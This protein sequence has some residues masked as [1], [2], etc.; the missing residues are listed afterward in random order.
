[1][2]SIGPTRARSLFSRTLLR[3]LRSER[4]LILAAYREIELDRKHPLAAALVEW[5][6]ERIA[7]RVSLERLTFDETS[8]LLATLFGQENISE[9]LTRAMYAETEGNPFFIEEV[10]KALIEQGQIY[11]E[12]NQWKRKEISELAIP[13]SVKEAI[14]RR[15]NRL[16]ESCLDVLHAAAALGKEFDYT[17]LAAVNLMSEDQLLDAL[18]EARHSPVGEGQEQRNRFPSL[19]IKSGKSCTRRLTRSAAS[20]CTSASAKPWKTNT[21]KEIKPTSRNW[22]IT[23]RRAGTWSAA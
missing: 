7:T 18:D 2:I 15:L 14:G 23:S 21:S 13:Q 4:V 20:A 19:T 3:N 8:A 16:S 6:R 5:N 9:E 1:M 22:L 12:N 10:V 17:E 11:R